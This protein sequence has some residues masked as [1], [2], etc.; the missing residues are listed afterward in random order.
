LATLVRENRPATTT[1]TGA[2]DAGEIRGGGGN[3][4]LRG[5]T[6]PGR[7]ASTPPFPI[8][9]RS[10]RRRG[11]RRHLRREGGDDLL[12]GGSGRDVLR[13]GAGNDTLF[14]HGGELAGAEL[15]FAPA[16]GGSV[17]YLAFRSNQFDAPDNEVDT[18]DGGEGDDSV[19]AGLGDTAIGG[20]WRRHADGRPARPWERGGPWTLA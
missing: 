6:T 2:Q 7:P 5:A 10:R 17:G 8:G 18:L 3:D 11:R 19:R 20:A 15:F 9:G 1:L 4:V 16:P 12:I 13:G 14:G